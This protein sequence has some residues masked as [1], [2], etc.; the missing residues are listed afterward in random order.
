[1]ST[2]NPFAE[3]EHGDHHEE[4]WLISYADMMTLLFGFFVLMYIFASQKSG[5]E[6]VRENLSKFFGGQYAENTSFN[7]IAEEFEA[8][9]AGSEVLKDV[10]IK[11]FP[12]GIEFTFRSTVLFDS[13]KAVI[14]PRAKEAIELLVSLISQ[15]EGDMG[16]VVEGH[17]DDVPINTSIFRSNWDLSGARASTVIQLFENTGF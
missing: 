13:G 8:I 12:D 11:V 5:A 6:S 4:P 7:A 9:L 14:L 1:M 10:D 3:E 2:N 15:Q 16:V 17:T